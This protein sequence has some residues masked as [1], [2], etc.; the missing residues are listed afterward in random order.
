MGAVLKQL[1]EER[2][3]EVPQGLPQEWWTQVA[4]KFIPTIF[5]GVKLLP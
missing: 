4:N 3:P 2:L 1:A 5:A